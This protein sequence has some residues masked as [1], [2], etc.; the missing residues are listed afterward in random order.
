[1]T[2]LVRI[3]FVA[4]LCMF[5][6]PDAMALD[7]GDCPG[8]KAGEQAHGDDHSHAKEE[9]KPACESCA[10][11]KAGETVWCDGCKA[12][13]HDGKKMKCQGCFDKASGKSDKGC[14]KCSH[15]KSGDEEG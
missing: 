2:A 5:A 3:F 1:M 14:E 13:Y 4:L 6:S 10:K 12:G 8:D 7:C 15:G 11:G 9:A